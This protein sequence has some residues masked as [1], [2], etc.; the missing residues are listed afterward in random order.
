M[1][2]SPTPN[3]PKGGYGG[4][5]RIKPDDQGVSWLFVVFVEGTAAL[6]LASSVVKGY[7]S[8]AGKETAER[9]GYAM[10]SL[11]LTL[12]VVGVFWLFRSMRKRKI[13]STVV[14]GMSG[15]MALLL[16]TL[17]PPQQVEQQFEQ[18]FMRGC[19]RSGKKAGGRVADKADELCRC[20]YEKLRKEVPQIRDYR[21]DKLEDM[22]RRTRSKRMQ[23]TRECATQ[24]G[25]M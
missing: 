4:S 6:L 24:V 20:M 5:A 16:F 21:R 15:L 10:G 9:I 13:L 14:L 2:S 19:V 22:K 8:Q 7:L 3:D 18:G 1:Q 17:A 11:I 12:I 23:W 25:I